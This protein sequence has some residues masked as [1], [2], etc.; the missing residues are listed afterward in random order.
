MT[1]SLHQVERLLAPLNP[2][3]IEKRKQA[4]ATLSYLNQA[5]VRAHAIR[6]FGFGG[7][8]IETLNTEMVFESENGGK[9]LCGWRVTVQ[10]TVKDEWN[11]PTCRYSE[12]A[13]GSPMGPMTDR[14]DAHDM[15]IKTATSDAMK[16]CFINLGDQFGLSLYNQGSTRPIVIDTLVK[17]G[18]A[19]KP[20]DAAVEEAV[21]VDT[22]TGEIHE[23]EVGIPN[24]EE[25]PQEESLGDLLSADYLLNAEAAVQALRDVAM[26]E[27]AAKR[28][29]TVAGI[30]VQYSDVMGAETFLG[31]DAISVG[32][33]A[34]MVAGGK[35][36]PAVKTVDE[37]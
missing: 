8:D 13:V 12:S 21:I 19:P 11:Q 36:V 27:D 31:K 30:K 33:L 7:V 32:V 2:A 25:E 23:P 4:G 35:F 20:L 16:R 6:M 18:A 15:A 1:F 26:E 29:L 9:W 34:D 22:E 28:I 24:P 3:R 17:P 5:D 10:I 37:S 14:S